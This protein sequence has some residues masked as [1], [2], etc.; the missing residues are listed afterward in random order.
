MNFEIFP[1]STQ[2]T[3]IDGL[4]F[5]D[6]KRVAEDRG[7]VRELFRKSAYEACGLKVQNWQQ[8]NLTYTTRG[9]VRGLHA[10]SMN[11]LITVAHGEVFGAYVDVRPQ[12]KTFK[13][14]YHCRITPGIQLLVPRGVC[15][16]F[17]AVS[18]SGAEYLYMFDEE[19]VSGMP[20]A[21]LTPL[22]NELGIPWPI[23]IDKNNRAQISEKDANAPTLDQLVAALKQ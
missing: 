16:G 11:K 17:Q 3:S 20:G 19:W 13:N 9:A 6:V 5:I 2:Q 14:I 15:N 18:E 22:D 8:V 1:M 4:T 23:P 7:E 10:E 12:S 21:A